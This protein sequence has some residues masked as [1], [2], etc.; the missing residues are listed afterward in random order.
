MIRDPT[1]Q[2]L[3]FEG[4][5]DAEAVRANLVEAAERLGLPGRIQSIDLRK[6]PPDDPRLCWG[7][8]TVLVNGV[9]LM[10][11]PPPSRRSLSCRI[12]AGGKP[13]G[14]DEIADR[15]MLHLRTGASGD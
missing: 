14:A 9:D 10:G 2:F 1:L 3:S 12:Y 4:C 6:L 5:P 7:S 15:L 8:P 13:P 11:Q